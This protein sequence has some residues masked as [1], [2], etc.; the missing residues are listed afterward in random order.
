MPML[1]KSVLL[2]LSWLLLTSPVF[3][4]AETQK[5][6]YD[7]QLEK[8]KGGDRTVDFTALRMAYTETTSY[9][10]YGG[11]ATSRKAMFEALNA[12]DFEKTLKL[13][14][15][16]LAINYMDIMGHFGCFVAN[17]ELSHPDKAD[18]HQFVFKGLLNSIKSSGDGKSLETAF[19]VISTDEEYALFNWLGVKPGTQALQHRDGHDYDQMTALDPKTNETTTYF[20]NIDKPFKWLSNSLKPKSN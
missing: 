19:V 9:S 11:P 3:G 1:S 13:A 6:R 2:C 18:Y 5:S 14:E 4:Q 20:F 7:I 12:K 16:I 10:P 15:E 17:R 8:L